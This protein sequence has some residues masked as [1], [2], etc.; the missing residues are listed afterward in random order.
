MLSANQLREHM[1]KDHNL[2]EA[3]SLSEGVLN[4]LHE[5]AHGLRRAHEALRA[6]GIHLGS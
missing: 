4:W 6:V 1:E 5:L 2:F 3:G